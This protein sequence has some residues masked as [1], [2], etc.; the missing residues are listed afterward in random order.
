M[1]QMPILSP[2]A[3]ISELA[4]PLS[5]PGAIVV[6]A[7]QIAVS[8]LLS[9]MTILAHVLFLVQCSMVLDFWHCL[10]KGLASTL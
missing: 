4:G 7:L 2:T 10:A 1:I 8:T 5:F 3:G 6:T 9:H